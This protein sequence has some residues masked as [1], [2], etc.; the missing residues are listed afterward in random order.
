MHF[1]GLQWFQIKA[2]ELRFLLQLSQFLHF[3]F[4]TIAQFGNLLVEFLLV[5]LEDRQDLGR[6]EFEENVSETYERFGWF[7]LRIE[8]IIISL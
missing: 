3:G 8:Q 2:F 5:I 7:L 4:E 6:G 1:L